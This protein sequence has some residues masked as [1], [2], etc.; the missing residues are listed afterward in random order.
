ML[1]TN[2]ADGETKDRGDRAFILVSVIWLAGLMAVIASA[3][4]INIR[5]QILSGANQVQSAKAELISD[6]LVYLTAWKLAAANDA[7]KLFPLNGRAWTCQWAE[8]VEAQI[9]VQDQSG[10]ID[11]NAAPAILLARAS[12]SA[13]LSA[14]AAQKLVAAI[15]DFR[16]SDSDAVGGGSEPE[17]YEGMNF[18]PKNAPFHAVEE[19]DQLPGVNDEVYRRLAPLLTVYSL[20]PGFDPAL[21]P[22]ELKRLLG[23]TN[24][25]KVP[26]E[27]AAFAAPSH[28]SAF[29]IDV[30]VTLK[31]GAVFR[32]HAIVTMLRQPERPFA[33]FGWQRDTGE[34]P[35]SQTPPQLIGCL[36]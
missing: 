7:S 27:L 10:L 24:D 32:R 19:I 14:E 12:Q 9:A 28:G 36:S 35:R 5:V 18:G 34:A 16:D 30:A 21:M 3:F 15:E 29:G 20:Q 11:L 31:S 13:G 23:I 22:A 1:K 17:T 6:G 2:H 33:I 26:S 8:G 4:A 25:N